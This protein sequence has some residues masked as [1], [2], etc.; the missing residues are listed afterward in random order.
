MPQL[1]LPVFPDCRLLSEKKKKALEKVTSHSLGEAA[2]NCVSS[3]WLP[4][5]KESQLALAFY[6]VLF[7]KVFRIKGISSTF[8]ELPTIRKI[9]C[10]HSFADKIHDTGG[11]VTHLPIQTL[12]VKCL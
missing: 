9:S 3:P 7:L 8:S 2:A 12:V 11:F 6:S 10:L 5:E 1:V 4:K